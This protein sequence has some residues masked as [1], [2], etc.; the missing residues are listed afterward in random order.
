MFQ[1]GYTVATTVYKPVFQEH[2][3]NLYTRY[4]RENFGVSSVEELKAKI[5]YLYGSG[6]F[7][8]KDL[9]HVDRLLST[10]TAS[11][12][13]AMPRY[14]PVVVNNV[15]LFGIPGVPI[16]GLMTIA[17]VGR[18]VRDKKAIKMLSYGLLLLAVALVSYNVGYVYGQA[19]SATIVIEPRSFTETAT[20]IIF[21]EDMDGDGILDIIYAKNGT[22]G[23][24]EFSGTSASAVIQQAMDALGPYGGKILIKKGVYIINATLKPPSGILISGE[25]PSTVLRLGNGTSIRV[26]W[27]DNVN[28]V[29][30]ENLAFDGNKLYVGEPDGMT[31]CVGIYITHN[32]TGNIIRNNYFYNFKSHSILMQYAGASGNIVI[33]NVFTNNDHWDFCSSTDADANIYVGNTLYNTKGIEMYQSKDNIIAFNTVLDVVAGVYENAAGGNL[34]VGNIINMTDNYGMYITGNNTQV[35]GNKILNTGTYGIEITGDYV[36]VKDN[37]IENTSSHA[38]ALY[39]AYYVVIEGNVIKTTDKRAIYVVSTCQHIK[40]FN[41]YL[42]SVGLT[43]PIVVET[44]A[45]DV[46]IEHNFG[47]VTENSGKFTITGDGASTTFTVNVTH[48]L[49]TDDVVAYATVAHVNVTDVDTYLND[50]DGDGIRETLVIVVEFSYPPANG[51]TIEGYWKAEAIKR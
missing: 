4:L 28:N 51:E 44:G 29:I 27:L 20:Y 6:G 16:L 34:Y 9:E 11:D 40:I 48:G 26:F 38:L 18:R 49:A 43:S 35:I 24:I 42:E 2:K 31:K 21:G 47:Y 12:Y 3:E 37:Y 36:I 17:A 15:A 10:G 13:V 32:S 8:I 5:M 41:N 23:E 19:L 46:V 45:T 22:T 50:T 7:D 1:L 14:E 39:K 33:G 25:G 30:I